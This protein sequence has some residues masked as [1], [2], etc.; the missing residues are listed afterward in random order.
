[1]TPNQLLE[2]A[3]AAANA[4]GAVLVE[5]LDQARTIDFKKGDRS[6]L[7]TDADKAAEK[8][9]LEVLKARVPDHGINAEESGASNLQKA[10]VWFLDPLDGTTNYAH[11]IPHYCT[12]LG[13]E[14]T[15][16]KKVLAGVVFDPI[17]NEMFTAAR[18]GGAFLNGLPIFCSKTA[19]LD[20]SVLSTGFPYDLR[21]NPEVPLFDLSADSL[22]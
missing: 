16:T 5:K 1:M 21:Q 10:F 9:A 2:V 18:G 13:V 11:G 17:R 12:T 14:D 20:T 3:I 22:G 8:A 6:D 19:T 7:V 4:S 15:K